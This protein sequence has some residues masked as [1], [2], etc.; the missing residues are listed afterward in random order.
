[1]ELLGINNRFRRGNRFDRRKI[2]GKGKRRKMA[3]SLYRRITYRV[4]RHDDRSI[5]E[6]RMVMIE[7]TAAGAAA[8]LVSALDGD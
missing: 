3:D 5:Y 1:M 4:S 8:N 6:L 2:S 7:E